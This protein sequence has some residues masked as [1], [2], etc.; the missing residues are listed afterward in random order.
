MGHIASFVAI[1]PLGA[2][3]DLGSFQNADE[4]IHGELVAVPNF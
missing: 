3:E 4:L 1:A 2:L